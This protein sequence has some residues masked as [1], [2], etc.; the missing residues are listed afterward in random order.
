MKKIKV[1]NPLGACGAYKIND[2]MYVRCGCEG[3]HIHASHSIGGLEDEET[4][5][6]R[7]YPF[8]VASEF[9]YIEDEP[10]ARTVSVPAALLIKAL[11]PGDCTEDA[12]EARR[13]CLQLLLSLL[14]GCRPPK[15]TFEQPLMNTTDSQLTMKARAIAKCLSY[16][17]GEHESAAKHMLLEMAHRLDAKDIRVH[18]KR[19]GLMAVNGIGKA[20]FLTIRERLLHWLFGV[21]PARV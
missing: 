4:C 13:Q 15:R 19:D 5:E 20:R 8:L 7:G 2:V 16:N 10:D 18:K 6:A 9:V 14:T 12:V 1:V 3:G 11:M 17:E 21:Q